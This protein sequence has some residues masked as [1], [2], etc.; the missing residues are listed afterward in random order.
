[1]INAFP[2]RTP[3]KLKKAVYRSWIVSET[4][5]GTDVILELSNVKEGIIFDSIIFRGIRLKAFVTPLK[6]GIIQIKSIIPSGRSRI[7]FEFTIVNL[8]DQLI[9]HQE[10]ERKAI[11][12]KNIRREKTKIY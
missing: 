12:L 10:S 5:R 3:F 7:R 2:S 9:Y 1:M 11:F 4:E 8:P 6:K